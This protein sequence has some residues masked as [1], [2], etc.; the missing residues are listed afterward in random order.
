[1][2]DIVAMGADRVGAMKTTVDQN[3]PRGTIARRSGPPAIL[4]SRCYS[5]CT[6]ESAENGDTSD[7]GFVYECEPRTFGELVREIESDG[8]AQEGCTD[9]LCTGYST[10][11]YRTGTEREETLHCARENPPHLHK[12][13]WLAAEI[14]KRRLAARR[15]AYERSVTP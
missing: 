6:P 3:S 12:W 8:F 1:M 7:S 2:F 13:F 5:E 14:A 4:V 11:D 10:Q 9:W 15:A